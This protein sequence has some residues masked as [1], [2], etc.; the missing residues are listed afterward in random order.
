[1][2]EPNT[3]IN[4]QPK[5]N[6]EHFNKSKGEGLSTQVNEVRFILEHYTL[7]TLLT[8]TNIDSQYLFALKDGQ[9]PIEKIS[10][11]TYNELLA[12]YFTREL[13]FPDGEEKNFVGYKSLEDK[14]YNQKLLEDKSSMPNKSVQ[15][16]AD[17][18]KKAYDKAVKKAQKELFGTDVMLENMTISDLKHI[19]YKN[20]WYNEFDADSINDRARLTLF[21]Y[22]KLGDRANEIML[23]DKTI[24]TITNKFYSE[25]NSKEEP[26]DTLNSVFLKKH[27][28]SLDDFLKELLRKNLL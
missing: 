7:S 1:M 19:L 28:D 13:D 22:K 15:K 14:K 16:I 10:I 25:E 27:Y 26:D 20:K 4:E 21:L 2:Y 5:V 12:L 18:S 17:D 23:E 24:N 11:Q 6:R 8:Y 3:Q 9:M